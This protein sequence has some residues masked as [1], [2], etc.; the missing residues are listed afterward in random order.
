MTPFQFVLVPM[1]YPPRESWRPIAECPVVVREGVVD[2]TVRV[3]S[4]QERMI[5]KVPEL[6]GLHRIS[7][8]QYPAVGLHSHAGESVGRGVGERAV[9]TV[10]GARPKRRFC[11]GRRPLSRISRA[12]RFLPQRCPR[13][14]RSSRMRGAVGVVTVFKALHDQRPQLGILTA[15][16]T[17]SLAPMRR[18]TTFADFEHCGQRVRGIF[19]G[20]RFHQRE[21]CGGIS[22]DK[23]R[24]FPAPSCPPRRLGRRFF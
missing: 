7:A 2:R 21:A 8:D 19:A 3:E 17:L 14:A 20:E 12:M 24:P 5:I 9:A 1:P 15:A 18:K 13:S 11:L 16:R 6:V 22:A 10:G 23:T 4:N